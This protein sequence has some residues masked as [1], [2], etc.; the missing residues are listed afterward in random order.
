MNYLAGVLLVKYDNGI[1]LVNYVA[2]ILLVKYD[3]RMFFL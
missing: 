1:L 3:T 2:G